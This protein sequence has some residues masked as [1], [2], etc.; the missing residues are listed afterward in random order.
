M[1]TEKELKAL[2]ADMTLEEKVDQMNQVAAG[3]FSGDITAMGPMAAKL[4]PPE[5]LA[6]T[7]SVL[8][9]MG[10]EALKKLQKEQIEKQPHKIPMLFMLDVINGFKTVYPIPLGQGASFDPELSRECAAMAAE[11]AAVSGVHVTFG[12]MTDLVRD[13]RWGRVMES[14]GEDPYL[15]SLFCAAMMPPSSPQWI[16]PSAARASFLAR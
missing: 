1:M 6:R 15:N 7:G 13:A 10:A 11:E 8:G 9:G 12:P 16:T 5:V 2:L 14:T 3:M 4:Y